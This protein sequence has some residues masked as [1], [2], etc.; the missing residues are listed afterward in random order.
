MRRVLLGLPAAL[1][2][3]AFWP[4]LSGGF[5][6]WDDPGNI[7][8]NPWLGAG[9][10]WLEAF[11]S[12]HYGH[13][14]PLAWLSLSLDKL[15]W[16]L[17]PF[18]FHLTAVLLHA[19][20]AVLLALLLHDLLPA[21]KGSSGVA[22]AVLAASLWAVH[23]LRVE[24][25][26]WATERRELL[27][28]VF[29]LLCARFHVAGKRD[30]ALLAFVAAG[31]SK[32]TAAVFPLVLLCHDH[33]R[34]RPRVKDKAAFFIVSGVVLAL[35]VRAQHLSGTAVPLEAFGVGDRLAQAVFA[36]G[37]YAWKTL[38]PVGLSPFVFVDRHAEAGRYYP[39]VALTLVI[40]ACAWPLRRRRGAAALTGAVLLFLA[41]SLGFFKSGP[42]TVADR[43]FHM[44]AIPLSLGAAFVLAR[45]ARARLAAALAVLVLLPLT[46]AQSALWR[47]SISLWTRAYESTPRPAP[48]VVQNLAAALREAGR[49]SEAAPLFAR[50]VAQAP[51]SPAAH[52]VRGDAAFQAGDLATAQSL[53]AAAL[54]LNADM[55][56]VRVNRGL[57][58]YRLGRHLE[59][60]AEF[61]R[62]ADSDPLNAEAWHNLGLCL[63]RRGARAPAKDALARALA[64]APGRAD[65][66]RVLEMIK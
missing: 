26:A 56:G 25:V 5:V 53:Y 1:V 42:Q 2:L 23:P 65:T 12:T 13:F 19:A 32:V 63:A 15:I 51:G 55:P 38:W 3:F 29:L 39:F 18:G 62:A 8:R 10:A 49:E 46:R 4:A 47:D 48:L 45:S 50:L 60:E 41:P 43:F 24:A 36:P 16:G 28:V 30:A 27:A 20:A 54:A 52:A 33:W 66:L 9:A 21:S 7:A 61:A 11:T 57:A 40:L 17:D 31:L 58:L 6:N 22:A 14:Q 59:A 44:A 35:G 37:W 64:L 34:G